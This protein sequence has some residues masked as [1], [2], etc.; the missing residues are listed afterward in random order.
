MLPTYKGN[1][2][3]VLQ[4]RDGFKMEEG[5]NNNTECCLEMGKNEE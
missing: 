5:I 3:I 4:H 1:K 2:D